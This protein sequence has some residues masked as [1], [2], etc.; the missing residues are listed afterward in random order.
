M[1]PISIMIDSFESIDELRTLS[2]RTESLEVLAILLEIYKESGYSAACESL[3]QY[4]I[5]VDA[6]THLTSKQVRTLDGWL[7]VLTCKPV[8][9]MNHWACTF[10]HN[11]DLVY[12]LDKNGF[13]PNFRIFQ[14]RDVKKP[15]KG[16]KDSNVPTNTNEPDFLEP[17]F[18]L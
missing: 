10:S 16:K 14:V 6:M 7:D 18:P 17:A 11:P 5:G 15:K 13:S 2:K 9:G 3:T 1:K 4:P 8:H 12:L